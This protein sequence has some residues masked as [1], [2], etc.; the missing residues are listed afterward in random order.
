[1]VGS[2]RVEDREQGMVK[3]VEVSEQKPEQL[4]DMLQEFGEGE[5]GFGGTGVATGKMSLDEYDRK[6]MF[7]SHIEKVPQGLG[8]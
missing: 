7:Y 2:Q 1:M 8:T 3:L 4:M 5:N 6:C